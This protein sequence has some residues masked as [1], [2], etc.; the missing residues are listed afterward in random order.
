VAETIDEPAIG[1]L[2]RRP[3]RPRTN[4][5]ARRAEIV[6]IAAQL[7][8]ERGYHATSI[9]DLAEAT[10]LQR[11]GLYH[12]IGSKENVLFDIHE[13]FIEP[14]L[15]AA[16]EIEARELPPDET[17]R[18]LAAALVHDIADYRDQVTVALHEWRTIVASKDHERVAKVRR[19]RGEFEA[20]VA[21][22]V[23]RGM[24]RGMFGVQRPRLAVLGLLGMINYA[25]QWYRP[26]SPY[27]PDEVASAF[28][29]FFID[30]I[31][32]R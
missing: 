31:R 13:R 8:A 16:R 19:A 15:E 2:P 10:G 22:A 25:Y 30:G 5:D 1:P 12:Y 32:V 9:G 4:H 11:G 27:A 7:F 21:R 18:A 24:E 14:L 23:Q 28:S 3:G 6:D 17:V 29:D 26:D 20:V